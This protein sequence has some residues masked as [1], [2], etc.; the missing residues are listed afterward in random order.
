MAK[1][2]AT[3]VG[4]M[5]TMIH[6]PSWNFV[7]AKTTVTTAVSTRADPVGHASSAASAGRGSRTES[8]SWITV[9][10]GEAADLP[11]AARHARLREREGQE[12]ADRV[13]RDEAG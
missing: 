12:D 6:A 8:R 13:E 10:G 4:M 1:K 9:P 7:T 11:P 2:S 5:M 3:R